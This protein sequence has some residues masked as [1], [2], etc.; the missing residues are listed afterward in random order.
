MQLKCNAN[1]STSSRT[2]Q[3]KRFKRNNESFTYPSLVHRISGTCALHVHNVIS[4]N[5]G[6]IKAIFKALTD[7]QP[8]PSVILCHVK[9]AFC[10]VSSCWP[11]VHRRRYAA[12]DPHTI[13]INLND[14]QPNSYSDIWICSLRLQHSLLPESLCKM[15]QTFL[16]S[17]FCVKQDNIRKRRS[18]NLALNWFV[19][20]VV[21]DH[22]R[23]F[24][25]GCLH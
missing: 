9:P 12:A 5:N 1:E 22:H 20:Y 24:S 3:K 8:T 19:W 11:A 16:S 25:S 6:E 13:M 23:T 14:T 18:L 21:L 10:H 17:Q 4:I 15:V 7:Q 2:R